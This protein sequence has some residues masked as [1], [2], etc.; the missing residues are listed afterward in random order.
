MVSSRYLRTGR[1]ART[2]A[3]RTAAAA[4]LSLLLMLGAACGGADDGSDAGVASSDEGGEPAAAR[5]GTDRAAVG[6]TTEGARSAAVESP[7]VQT[8]AVISTATLTLAADDVAEVRTALDRLLGRYGG[9]V[10]DEESTFRQDGTLAGSALTLRVPAPRFEALMGD[11]ADLATVRDRSR[12]AEDVTTEVIDVEARIAT[13]EVSLR[14]LRGFLGEARDVNA[15]V[16]LESEI[17][18]REASLGSLRAQQEYLADQT[19]LATVQVRLVSSSGDD[20][21]PPL[22]A[23]GFLAGLSSGWDA[24]LGVGTVV[25]TL[26][27]AVV[28]FAALL[29]L[30]GLPIWLLS[31][32]SRRRRTRP[33]PAPES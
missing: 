29:G 16:R 4:G 22:A 14:R 11:F 17:A 31:R 7:E 23:S 21:E 8:R 26:A 20:P 12:K 27:G 1:T 25:A 33:E 19:A 5:A 30:V 9:H 2:A 32:A 10:A 3:A 28:P 18:R 6:A 15:M 24:L 13:Q